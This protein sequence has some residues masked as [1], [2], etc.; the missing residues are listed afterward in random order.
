MTAAE[1]G[2]DAKKTR[3][4]VRVKYEGHPSVATPM[5]GNRK[6]GKT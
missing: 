4:S 1:I 5:F 3:T 2:G 6:L